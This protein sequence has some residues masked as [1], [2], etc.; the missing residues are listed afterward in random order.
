MDSSRSSVTSVL[1]LRFVLSGI[2]TTTV[3]AKQM[4][5]K[6]RGRRLLA[7]LAIR[8]ADGVHHSQTTRTFDRLLR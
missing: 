8:V 5:N 4:R 6:L 2:L 3:C 1:E 7:C